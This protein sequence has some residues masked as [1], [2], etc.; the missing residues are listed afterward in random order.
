[1]KSLEKDNRGRKRKVDGGNERISKNIATPTS[2]IGDYI[3]TRE[4]YGPS[5]C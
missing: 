5:W 4:E 1:M 3:R 2:I